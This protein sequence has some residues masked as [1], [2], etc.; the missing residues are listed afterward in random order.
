MMIDVEL[1]DPLLHVAAEDSI[2]KNRLAAIGTLTFLPLAPE[3]WR[4][5]ATVGASVLRD[6]EEATALDKDAI[7][8]LARIPVSSMRERLGRIARDAKH[9]A[10]LDGALALA[11]QGDSKG[12]H[13]LLLELKRT[14]N[15]DIAERLACLP[16]ERLGV[17]KEPFERCLIGGGPMLRFWL[18]SRSRGSASLNR[19]NKFG[20]RWWLMP[21]IL[22]YFGATRGA[23]TTP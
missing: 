7:A 21:E 3:T 8:V 22:K 19:W 16:I 18:R 9:P 2:T 1:A 14:G 12:L 10:S 15:P 5:V 17:T 20:T 13:R 4:A 23:L 11:R 6:L